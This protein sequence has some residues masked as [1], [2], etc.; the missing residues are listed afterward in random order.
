MRPAALSSLLECT[1][2]RL[3]GVPAASDLHVRGISTDTRTLRPGEMYLALCGANFDGPDFLGNAVEKGATVLC[4][5][6]AE[7]LS[8]ALSNAP[9]RS[10]AALL[11]PDTLDAYQ[12]IAAW[13]RSTLSCRVIAVTGSVGK[14][15]TRDMVASALS[16]ERNVHRTAGN[17]N[18]AI[19]LPRTL[20][21]VEADH[22]VCVLELGMRGRG[23]IS[24]LS[25]IA[26][27]D[28][29][30][31]TSIGTS[32]IEFLGSREAILAAKMEVVE[33][34]RPGGALLLNLDDPYLLG[35]AH[36][37]P[38]SGRLPTTGR[39]VELVALRTESGPEGPLPP[40]CVASLRAFHI[41]VG[42]DGTRFDVERSTG[43]HAR[44]QKNLWIPV[45]GL[46]GVRN[47]LFGIASADWAGVSPEASAAGIAAFEPTGS[48]MRIVGLGTMTLID[49]SYNASP[50]S[51]AAAFASLRALSAGRRTLAALGGMNELG[52]YAEEAH[53]LTGAAAAA[54]DISLVLAVGPHSEAL[55]EGIRTAEGSHT[56]VVCLPDIAALT[57]ALLERLQPGDVLLV[58]GS[59]SFGMERVSEA[60][61]ERFVTRQEDPRWT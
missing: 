46:H 1:G 47:A 48:R 41:R 38:P 51:M 55:A 14:T 17:L 26:A 12:R 23:E 59:R 53:R 52:S 7:R 50:E 39:R 43:G 21:E 58:K 19:G 11:V 4:A 10:V 2:A 37:I 24:L 29:A 31:V 44:I 35:F 60:V 45:P 30:A 40:A 22:E 9:N 27:P 20:L 6:D 13:Y 49:D 28:A 33:G 5:S 42:Q 25:R 54:A 8:T 56:E 15:S 36:F 32:H 18:N 16:K 34:L 61:A 57:A 3:V